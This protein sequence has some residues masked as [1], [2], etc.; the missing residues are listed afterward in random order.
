[1]LP[2]HKD[3]AGYILSNYGDAGKIVEVGIGA[4]DSLFRELARKKGLEVLATDIA[5]IAGAYRDDAREPDMAIYRGADLIYSI[6]PPPELIPHL[7]RIADHVG[8]SL[9]IRPLSTD[10]CCKPPS[11]RLVNH[12]K[13]VLW[14]KRL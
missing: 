1:M 10:S 4:E 13:A 14:E 12:G 9:L 8:A 11:M 7:E 2:D 5:P 3:I 6:R